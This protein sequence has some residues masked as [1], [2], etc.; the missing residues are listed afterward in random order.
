M[1]H[2]AARQEISTEANLKM[3]PY[4]ATF[5]L[6]A[7]SAIGMIFIQVVPP[8]LHVEV[9]GACRQS[10]WKISEEFM[11]IVIR[12]FLRQESGMP[13]VVINY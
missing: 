8:F 11:R 7:S 6:Y 2:G 4:H 3:D 10:K 9:F 12:P 1:V 5:F 13:S